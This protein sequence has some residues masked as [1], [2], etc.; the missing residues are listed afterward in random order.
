MNWKNRAV[1]F[2]ARFINRNTISQ[3][4]AD[5]KTL[6][7]ALT[8]RVKGCSGLP[9]RFGGSFKTYISQHGLDD[10]LA[11]LASGLDARSLALLEELKWRL[12]NF[13]EQSRADAFILIPDRFVTEQEKRDRKHWVKEFRSLCRQYRIAPRYCA[14]EAFFYHH[15]LRSLPGKVH[16]YIKSSDF[17][18]AGAYIGD[19]AV[20][21]LR[22][23]SPRKVWSFDLCEMNRPV[24]QQLMNRNDIAPE[25]YEFITA[26]TGSANGSLRLA[27]QEGAS[28]STF[29]TDGGVTIPTTT[30]DHF[31]DER[32]LG[33]IGFIKADV[34]GKGL[35]MAKGMTEILRRDRP[36][37][38]LSIYHNP[39]EFFELKPFLESLNLN[40]RFFLEKY[41][42]EFD[43]PTV[44]TCL[45]AVPAE[46]LT[47]PQ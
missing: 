9:D 37:L 4:E 2:A 17:I 20:V 8:G 12:L 38:S 7:L 18:D 41:R 26:A 39:D 42:L 34:E 43:F 46:L 11:R 40:Y 16:E 14:P 21:L 33:R 31:A 22:N 29:Q 6:R 15:G 32:R 30:L 10:A 35:E 44:D 45:L 19:S 27:Q 24:Y 13:P 1:E 28:A 36:V 5:W 25:Q 47:A 3:W 23:Y